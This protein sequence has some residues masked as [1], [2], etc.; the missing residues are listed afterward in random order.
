MLSIFLIIAVVTEK[1]RVKPS[2]AIPTCAPTT[3]TEEIIQTPLLV[4]I[5]I[6]LR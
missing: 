3:L 6:L 2:P 1:I 5:M 4:I